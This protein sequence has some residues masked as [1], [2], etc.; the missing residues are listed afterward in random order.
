MDEKARKYFNKAWSELSDYERMMLGIMA[1]KEPSAPAE[2]EPVAEEIVEE[3]PGE[4]APVEEVPVEEAPVEEAPVEEAPVE[5]AP[6]EETPIEEAPVE[7]TPVEDAPVEEAPVEETPVEDAPVEETPVEEAPVVIPPVEDPDDSDVKIAGEEASAKPRQPIPLLTEEKN[8]ELEPVVVNRP[9]IQF[10]NS[11]EREKKIT[12]KVKRHRL[13]SGVVVL[14]LCVALILTA[15]LYKSLVLK[16]P[17]VDKTPPSPEPSEESVPA[18]IAATPAPTPTPTPEPTPEH[19]YVIEKTPISWAAAQDRCYRQGGYLAV[20]NTRDEF[21]K[22]TA[23]ADEQG[24]QFLWIGAKRNSE[25]KRFMWENSETVESGVDPND[26]KMPLWALGEPN[27]QDDTG[28][29]ILWNK[30]GKGW[31]YWDSR[32]DLDTLSYEWRARLAYVCEFDS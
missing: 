20:I 31:Y 18:E 10:M 6:V 22:I 29:L 27:F 4:E 25:T 8:P 19:R 16:E 14:G 5:E 11:I 30:D 23:M 2:E 21:N 3:A 9:T 7:E 17:I 15:V 26:L 1:A 24:I 12:R 32:G 28:C 13:R